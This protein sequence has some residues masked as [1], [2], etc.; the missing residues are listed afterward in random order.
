MLGMSMRLLSIY[1]PKDDCLVAVHRLGFTQD[2]D[3]IRSP[4]S[5]MP[6]TRW[7]YETRAPVVVEDSHVRPDPFKREFLDRFG[8]RSLVILP[9]MS[10]DRKVGSILMADGQPR[11]LSPLAVRLAGLWADQ[12]AALLVNLELLGQARRLL[13]R[14]RQL[15][16][17]REAM[18][19]ITLA[20]HKGGS[21]QESLDHI[22]QLAPRAVGV[23]RCVVVLGTEDSAD[24]VVAAA[25][26]LKDDFPLPVGQKVPCGNAQAVMA[27]GEP[28]LIPD[29]SA[30]PVLRAR[31][32]PKVGSVMYVSLA[33]ETGLLGVVCFVREAKGEFSS[34]QLQAA[35]L[36]CTRAA[37]AIWR[38]R[39]VEQTARDHQIKT[40]LLRELNHRVKNNLAGII[41][42]LSAAPPDLSSEAREWLNLCI[43]RISAMAGA[44]EIFVHP[45]GTPDLRSVFEKTIES[46]A[47]M[48]SP[49]IRVECRHEL[50]EIK[51]DPKPAV[52][53]AMVLHE[54]CCNAIRHALGDGG[55][56]KLESGVSGRGHVR[57]VVEDV[58]SRM[59]GRF[60]DRLSPDGIAPGHGFG[61]RLVHGLVTRE[62]SGSIRLTHGRDGTRAEIEV[63]LEALRSSEA[64]D[65]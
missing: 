28:L 10:G 34:E 63:P 4:L 43:A 40:V 31:N 48:L 21:L 18:H 16:Q 1:D 27:S 3:N 23:D 54:L 62:L 60:K 53:L 36:L 22:A 51:I 19:E 52:T 30:D 33:G 29:A 7:A 8:A 39:L 11:K 58:A 9:L 17:Q 2:L 47:T 41:T 46:L 64:V 44:Q 26:D 14:E 59:G 50:V 42:L 32:L 37:D 5:V 65:V 13:D 24:I 61:L 35:R 55:V 15:V 56:L 6:A 20:L 49:Q 57:I 25:T 45:V 12:A 38:N